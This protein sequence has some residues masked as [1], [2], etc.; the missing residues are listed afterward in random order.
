MN[1]NRK[2]FVQ[3]LPK[4]I[5]YD[6][7]VPGPPSEPVSASLRRTERREWWLWLASIVVTLM[8]T[9][10]VVSFILPELAEYKGSISWMSF[11]QAVRGLV[12]VVL[13]FDLYTIYQQWQIHRIRR[14]LFQREELFRL[15]SDNATDMIAVVDME[16]RRIYNSYSYQTVLG[17]SPEELRR[18]SSLEQIHPDDRERVKQAAEESRATGMGQTLEYRIRHK[19]GTW[20]ML[21]YTASVIHNAKGGPEKLVIVNPDITD[22]QLAL[23]A[24]RLADA[25]FRSV[26]EDAPYGIYRT[27]GEGQLFRVN[28]ALQKILGYDD[29]AELLKANLELQIFRSAME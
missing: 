27:N 19:N 2:E 3:K 20:R 17:Y 25:D 16:G 24:F 7:P 28:P 9:G 15:I 14:E 1:P 11:P 18:S 6:D 4:T 21:E 23:E 12:A 8:L 22:R 10:G 26:V 29:S 5:F 13:L